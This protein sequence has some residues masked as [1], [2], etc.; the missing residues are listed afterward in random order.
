MAKAS[1]WRASRCSGTCV[2][3]P[4]RGA[5]LFVRCYTS[6]TV[7]TARP[8]HTITE[9]DDVAQALDAAAGR[10]PQDAGARS[11][12]LLRLIA[13]GQQAIAADAESEARRRTEAVKRTAGAFTSIY[14]PDYLARLR[15]DWPD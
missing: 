11:R 9:T 1:R 6:H 15:E 2:R 4:K 7:P 5:A 14:P 12:L 3:T 8:R 10:W 13:A